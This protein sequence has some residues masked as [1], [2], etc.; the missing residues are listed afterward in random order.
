MKLTSLCSSRSHCARIILSAFALVL[1]PILVGYVLFLQFPDEM[2]R[3]QSFGNEVSYHN[4][5]LGICRPDQELTLHRP[6]GIRLSASL[7]CPKQRGKLPAI[8]L[9]HGSTELG[10]KKA[11][12]RL[13]G[14]RLAE[15]GYLVVAPDLAGFGTSQDPFE[16]GN[17]PAIDAK[18]DIETT[19]DWLQ[20]RDDVDSQHI[21]VIAHSGSCMFAMDVATWDNRIRALVEIGPSRNVTELL[22]AGEAVGY[23]FQRTR[24]QWLHLYH[25]DFPAWYTVDVWYE[26]A[27]GAGN[28]TT[29][30][31]DIARLLPYYSGG[32]HLPVLMV[33]G[34]REMS[35]DQHYL[36][37]YF[38][39]MSEPK[40]YLRLK[41]GDHYCN[42][43]NWFS[44]VLYDAKVE[45]QLLA[46]I[47]DWISQTNG[48][49]QSGR[50]VGM[51]R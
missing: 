16:A 41:N 23:F 3:I 49:T 36:E 28:S 6:D 48:L 7:F 25:R 17:A 26:Q 35:N 14:K 29:L 45:K 50:E 1:A 11:L 47:D 46:G 15:R 44:L 34:S 51:V 10:R 22:K 43:F 19:M 18:Q 32:K 38:K 39:A 33:D 37:G 31:G 42:T 20:Q 27:M 4:I 30:I 5:R 8:V 24:E 40:G 21:Y 2:H 12:F 13:M 9:L